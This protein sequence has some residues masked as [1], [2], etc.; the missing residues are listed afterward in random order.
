LKERKKASPKQRATDK[1]QS[2]TRPL[3]NQ[4]AT[5]LLRNIPSQ[6]ESTENHQTSPLLAES[7]L[8]DMLRERATDLHLDSHTQGILVRL[9]IDGV[10]H[11]AVLLD[12]EL[13][14]QLVNQFKNLAQLDPVIRF[15]AEDARI[16]YELDGKFIDLRLTRAPCLH[17]DKLSLRL[18]DV[19]ATPH[20]LQDLGLHAQGLEAINDWLGH[21][22]GMLL[23]AGPA[24]SGKTTTLYAL[25]HRLKLD[26]RSVITVEDP[27]EYQVDGI[28]HIQVD[29]LHGMNF[30]EGVKAMLR[31][32]PDFLMLGE[33]RDSDSARAAL[34]A[35]SS[36]RALMS[37]LHSR[38]AVAVVETLRN[39]GLNG[40]EIS[41]N[42]MLVISQ[43]LVRLLCPHCRVKSGPNNEEKHWLHELGRPVPRKVWHATG[44]A[45]CHGVGYKGRT[46]IFEVWRIDAGEYQLILDDTD[47]RTLYRHLAD[48]GH[49]FLLDDGLAKAAEGLTTLSELRTI[50]GYSV[51]R[52]LDLDDH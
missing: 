32:D 47:R 24:G 37:T 23:V 50:G 19:P 12:N 29:K 49:R 15:V 42:L 4:L 10:L 30:V 16:R 5:E 35:A 27:T 41:A 45:Q 25:L 33:I 2:D 11:D 1:V 26:E 14:R 22:S 52:T 43:R 9:R 17:G 21:V 48:R 13:G 20:Q 40:H 3:R 39:Y 31:L 44:C 7:L 51:L 34:T 28:N 38:D 8:R 36:G 46:G 6:T 18:F